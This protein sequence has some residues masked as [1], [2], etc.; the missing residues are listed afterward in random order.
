MADSSMKVTLRGIVKIQSASS[1][2]PWI[3]CS[4]LEKEERGMNVVFGI[5]LGWQI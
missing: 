2:G 1:F 3:S 5:A 4:F